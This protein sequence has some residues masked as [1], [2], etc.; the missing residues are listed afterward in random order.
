M[1]KIGFILLQISAYL[2]LLGAIADFAMTF[3]T[4]SLPEAHLQ[5]LKLKNEAVS[6][7]LKNLDHFFLRAIGGCLIGIGIGAL[8]IIYGSLKKKIKF[9]LL[10]LISMVT[11]GEGI[12]AS[13]MLMLSSPYFIFPLLC[14]IIT[15][16]GATFWVIGNR[17]EILKKMH[18]G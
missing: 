4:S 13:Q 12:N 16:T 2:I 17:R 11:I 3:Y 14:V 6:V 7:E 18:N 9:S 1:K 8:T 15:W 5:Y 10:G